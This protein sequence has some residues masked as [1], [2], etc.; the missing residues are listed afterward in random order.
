MCFL[1]L[2]SQPVFSI[3]QWEC[4]RKG[5]GELKQIAERWAGGGPFSGI[6]TSEE[7]APATFSRWG[8]KLF[9]MQRELRQPESEWVP[10][11]LDTHL[12][13]GWFNEAGVFENI[14]YQSTR[15]KWAERSKTLQKKTNHFFLRS[16]SFVDVFASLPWISPLSFRRVYTCLVSNLNR[17]EKNLAS[18]VD[19]CLQQEAWPS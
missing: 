16:S 12:Q 4:G 19:I 13:T 1:L 18:T 8:L 3:M 11:T 15:K 10:L 9:L 17:M 6:C 14:P 5:D 2:L 7:E